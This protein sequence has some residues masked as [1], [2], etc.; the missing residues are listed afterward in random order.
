MTIYKDF[1]RE[2]KTSFLFRRNC[3]PEPPQCSS[4]NIDTFNWAHQYTP[5]FFTILKNEILS[6]IIFLLEIESFT[7]GMFTLPLPVCGIIGSSNASLA[8]LFLTNWSLDLLWPDHCWDGIAFNYEQGKF[9]LRQEIASLCD[10]VPL[11]DWNVSQLRPP[12]THPPP[13]L[14]NALPRVHH[15]PTNDPGGGSRPIRRGAFAWER[16]GEIA[17]GRGWGSGGQ[18]ARTQPRHAILS[19]PCIFRNEALHVRRSCLP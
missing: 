7:L 14:R 11:C 4:C 8:F 16:G 12:T 5:I 10:K 9:I 15:P 18:S 3:C 13:T 2:A 6:P 1:F 17:L 19:C